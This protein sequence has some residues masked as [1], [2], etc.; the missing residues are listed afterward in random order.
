MF[1]FNA[2]E[3]L[4]MRHDGLLRSYEVPRAVAH[5]DRNLQAGS[6]LAGAAVALALTL[7]IALIQ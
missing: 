1:A 5:D 6:L 4:A 7:V 2:S 3:H